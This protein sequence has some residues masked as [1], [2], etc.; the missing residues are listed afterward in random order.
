LNNPGSENI[1]H[2]DVIHTSVLQAKLFW[3]DA[4]STAASL[5]NPLILYSAAAGNTFTI[6]SYSNPL[7]GFH[8]PFSEIENSL[9]QAREQMDMWCNGF[10][11]YLQVSLNNPSS[12]RKLRLRFV[13]GNPF[14][15]CLSLN[16]LRSNS[17]S[18]RFEDQ[19]FLSLNCDRLLSS[20]N[21]IDATNLKDAGLLNVFIS[22]L[23]LLSPSSILYTRAL[24]IPP[25]RKCETI[26]AQLLYE[27]IDIMSQL[28]G[29]V[30]LAHQPTTSIT[31][32]DQLPTGQSPLHISWQYQPPD[33]IHPIELC[34]D[35]IQCVRLLWKIYNYMFLDDDYQPEADVQSN[36]HYY[37]PL[38]NV[39]SFCGL[40]SLLRG[41]LT[42]DWNRMIAM[43]RALIKRQADTTN[44]EMVVGFRLGLH[45]FGLDSFPQWTPAEF[46]HC[47]HC[48]LS[49]THL[50]PEVK[51]VIVYI[52]ENIVNFLLALLKPAKGKVALPFSINFA[53]QGQSFTF[54]LTWHRFGELILRTD[55]RS[56]EIRQ[57]PKGW[58]GRFEFICIRLCSYFPSSQIRLSSS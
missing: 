27:N 45:L 1:S 52:P 30:S 17:I 16:R 54:P 7:V 21:V 8:F 26:L 43:L 6:M 38:Y 19:C 51:C 36:A 33:L 22:A 24:S 31:N 25:V 29:L 20:F 35:L 12:K 14:T 44:I 53:T 49:R 47:N 46:D 34:Q 40:L 58:N 10:K 39:N 4:S 15:F 56:C 41:R 5:L 11:R 50:L 28:F 37:L 48:Q 42:F 2:S 18:Y 3:K 57:D 23:P 55:G 13:T 9:E 32:R